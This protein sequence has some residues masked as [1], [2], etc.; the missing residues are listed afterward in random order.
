MR[1]KNEQSHYGQMYIAFDTQPFGFE[2]EDLCENKPFYEDIL[3]RYFHPV[4]E[5]LNSVEK[6]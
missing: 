2:K 3:L 1:D 5:E 6:S 4:M